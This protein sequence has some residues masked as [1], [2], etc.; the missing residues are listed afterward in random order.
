M[1]HKYLIKVF[2]L[3]LGICGLWMGM[4]KVTFAQTQNPQEPPAY[5][6]NELDPTK[7]AFSG[8]DP[9]SLIHNANLS[10]SRDGSTFAEDTQN[11]LNKAAE[12]FKR[13]QQLQLQ[14]KPVQ[15]APANPAKTPVQP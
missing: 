13:Q 12:N 14:A 9:M 10:R 15:V 1:N 5:Q 7:G 2:S 6:S 8:F 11:S 3:S 4:E